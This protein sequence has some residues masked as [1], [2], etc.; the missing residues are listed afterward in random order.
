MHSSLPLNRREALKA[1]AGFAALQPS[2]AAPPAGQRD[3]RLDENWRF[4][5]GDAPGAEDPAFNDNA[6]RAVLLPH[7][8]SIEDRP[9]TPDST[10]AAAVWNDSNSPARVGPFDRDR[11]EG[12]GSTG[13]VVGGTAWYRT[14]LPAAF[15]PG[16]HLELRF[17]GVYMNAD[18]WINGHLLGNHPYGY[19]GFAYDI[20]PHLR[21][22]GPNV[23]AVRVRNE[24]QNSRWYSGSGITRHVWLTTTGEVRVPLWGVC[25]T[26]PE[27]QPDSATV[28]IATRLE[29]RGQSARNVNVRVRLFD[30]SRVPAGSHDLP[31]SVPTAGETTAEQVI[32]VPR[33]KLWSSASPH[34]Y[35]AE[36]ELSIDGQP[37]DRVTTT[38][39]IRKIEVDAARGLR[40][41]GEA[42]KLKGA[43]L[44]HDNGILGTA[45]IDRAE[46]RRVELMKAN[47]YNAIRTSH[48]PPAPAFLDA[49]DRLGILVIDEAFDMWAVAKNPQDYH[50]YFKD[51][52]Q[53][54]LDA[55][56]LRDRNHP[57]VIFWSIG[58]E[59]PERA[60]PSGIA[61]AKQ[62]ADRVRQLDPTRRI[63]A[64]V[65][66]FFE[67][68]VKRPWTDT[69]AA[70]QFLDVCGYNYQWQQ[71]E[72]DH[73]RHPQRVM[74]GTE[75]F[76][77]HASENW[78]LIEKHPYVL[79]DFVWTGMDYI[80]ESSLGN[81][82]LVAPDAKSPAPPDAG[83][84]AG[85]AMVMAGYPW[86]NAYCGDI[87]LIG[88]KKPQSYYRDVVW[89]R[90][91]L[92]M[93][94]QRPLPADRIE[95]MSFWGWSDELRSWTWPG[96]V[97]KL[98][99]VRVYTTGDQVRLLLNGKEL[100]LQSISAQSKY[101]AEFSVPY[102]PG[103]LKAIALKDGAPIAELI[104]KTTGKPAQLRLRP[105]RPRL[106]RDRNDLAFI[107]VDVLD[108]A[109][110]LV[111]DA[112]V[113]IRFT[114]SGPCTLAAVGNANPKEVASF[115][116][117]RRNT[118]HGQCLAVLRPTGAPGLLTLQVESDGLKPASLSIQVA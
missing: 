76:A 12:K 60:D 66:F 30:S 79:G 17:D 86:F 65:P 10:G 89:G 101:K 53:R 68:N 108:A 39:G 19:T 2:Q 118:Y 3:Q 44:H 18:V 103:E 84:P 25:I 13:W 45:S 46:E 111:P 98:L 95:Q 63:T 22:A 57:S 56:V 112:V 11:S 72:P 99:A 35:T 24:G 109:G 15:T 73:A 50:L 33:P 116:Q 58:N 96:A 106:H 59:I 82:R 83:I 97:G 27:V 31:Q 80:G 88:Q 104:F 114:L 113:P 93:A 23:V 51:W 20:T 110:N 74:M 100:G 14:T 62:L 47:G 117:P 105:D 5:L 55:M 41:N 43:C 1:A 54:D 90:S 91:K 6:W 16:R 42:V 34:L 77:L 81:S 40:I 37:A 32:S 115:R 28:K 85:T 48:N 7:D 49:C 29:N 8:W 92:E 61:I 26:T 36:I 102:A 4:H 9:L 21:P 67:P 75:S 70:F 87:D 78:Q 69:D 94:V 52:W 71:Y 107:T 38:F 64:A